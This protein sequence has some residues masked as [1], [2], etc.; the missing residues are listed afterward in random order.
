M[1]NLK[2]IILEKLVINKNTDASTH[3]NDDPIDELTCIDELYLLMD[4]IWH[5]KSWWNATSE[6]PEV[7]RKDFFEEL[8]DG[9]RLTYLQG[10][11]DE[12]VD[13]GRIEIEDADKYYKNTV[14]MNACS[15]IAKCILH[16]NPVDVYKIY[17]KEAKR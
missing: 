9:D 7:E 11:F 13:R 10:L 14:I 8:I 6:S 12:L 3:H 5:D 1:K 17:N 16:D 4:E 15:E 2:D